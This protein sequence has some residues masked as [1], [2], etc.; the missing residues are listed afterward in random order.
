MKSTELFNND[1]YS[2]SDDFKIVH[3]KPLNI[4]PSHIRDADVKKP[5]G[6]ELSLT[7]LICKVIQLK[8]KEKEE[9]NSENRNRN[10]EEKPPKT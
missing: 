1:S 2:E 7:Q 9:K 3:V 8:K 6:K 5:P 4:A 10:K